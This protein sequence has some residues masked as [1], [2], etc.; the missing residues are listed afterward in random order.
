MLTWRGMTLPGVFIQEKN[1]HD[2]REFPLEL[3]DQLLEAH[4]YSS[5]QKSSTSFQAFLGFILLQCQTIVLQVLL[6]ILA[7]FNPLW[8]VGVGTL[9]FV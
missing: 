1:E 2:S 4:I 6:W 7:H 8:P 5:A 9:R 3:V